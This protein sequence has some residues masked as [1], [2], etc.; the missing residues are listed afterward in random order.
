MFDFVP[1]K[2]FNHQTLYTPGS[3]NVA[4]W[5]IKWTLNESMYFL[6]E[7]GMILQPAILVYQRVTLHTNMS[8]HDPTKTVHASEILESMSQLSI[9]CLPEGRDSMR[10]FPSHYL[11]LKPLRWKQD[12][13]SLLRPYRLHPLPQ[14]RGS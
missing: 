10:F 7:M 4:G 9:V 2:W 13:P 8:S 6:L 14:A 3:T 12:T 11:H 1:E 5:K